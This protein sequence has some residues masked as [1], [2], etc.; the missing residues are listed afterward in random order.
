MMEVPSL[1]RTPSKCSTLFWGDGCDD[2][3]SLPDND[4]EHESR[5]TRDSDAETLSSMTNGRQQSHDLK[6]TIDQSVSEEP[7]GSDTRHGENIPENPKVVLTNSKKRAFGYFLLIHF[8]PVA[9]TLA[10]FWLYLKGFQWN[11]S[12]VQLKS[13]LFAAKLHEGLI[14]VSLG[15]ILFHR[16]RYHLMTSRGV[17]FGLLVSPFRVSDPTFLFRGPFLAS[18]S[19]SL[20]SAP[21]LLTV[22][23]VVLVSVLGMLAAPSSG[24]LMIPKYDWWPIPDE[25]ETITKFRKKESESAMYIGASFDDL[26]PLLVDGGYGPDKDKDNRLDPTSFSD[27]FEH[28]LSG[29]D[30]I[31]VKDSLGATANITVVDG[32]TIDSFALSYQERS[33][34]E[35][36]LMTC[37]NISVGMNKTV[38]QLHDDGVDCLDIICESLAAQVTSPLALVTQELF[39]R[40]RAWISITSGVAMI[41]AK[42]SNKSNYDLNWRQ[43]SVS[44]Q[45]STV[46]YEHHTREKLRPISFDDLGSFSPF[47]LDLD[48]SFGED[49]RQMLKQA[50]PNTTYID[51]SHLL[52]E[53]IT[54]STA[55]I[56]YDG[57]SSSVFSPVYLCLVDAR[58]IESQLWFTAPYATITRSGVPMDSISD[59][60]GKKTTSKTSSVIDITT[61]Y[62][63][64]LD[65]NLTVDP[66]YHQKPAETAQVRPFAFIRRYCGQSVPQGPKCQMLAH[67]VYLTD[68]LRRTQSY[69]GYYAASDV[70]RLGTNSSDYQKK[71]PGNLTR[72]D[73][74]LYH[75]LHAYKFEGLI[76]KLSMSVLLLHMMLVYAHLLLLVVGDGWYSRAWSEL[77][78]LMALAILTRPSSLL[79]N[80]TGGVKS[81]QTWKLRTFIRELT[82]D[83]RLEIVLKE[84]VNSPRVLSEEEGE[85]KV[86]VEPEAN[87]RYG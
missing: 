40:Y 63:N 2:I 58:W 69:F 20:K 77:G 45:C 50:Q 11:A 71:V 46:L 86:H 39:D 62:A 5:C 41:K 74:Q 12:D 53:E 33:L 49:I 76:V 56:M 35:C 16:I 83:G 81:W 7:H 1:S 21:E 52:P 3:V 31:L 60:T 23:L 38:E 55:L 59:G 48:D 73:Y 22:S 51:I 17:S 44:M 29:L 6:N 65:S 85:V 34:D 70:Y 15:E 54:I 79:Q 61:E 82:P 19:F 72:L 68:S 30:Q 32:A 67:T 10:L 18:A 75:Q 66:R 80:A 25:M 42:P 26:F 37:Q 4:D 14:L 84:T 8:A 13:L 87:R 78:E 64:S 57:N 36:E 27:R 43:P 47:T 28:I 9:G 24:A